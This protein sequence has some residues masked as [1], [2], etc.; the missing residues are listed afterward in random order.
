MMAAIDP[1]SPA[2]DRLP[3]REQARIYFAHGWTREALC[4]EF[5]RSRATIDVWLNPDRAV[6]VAERRRA[7]RQKPEIKA[8]RNAQRQKARARQRMERRAGE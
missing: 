5:D 3:P 7:N 8:R 4:D 1:A 2:F 6:R